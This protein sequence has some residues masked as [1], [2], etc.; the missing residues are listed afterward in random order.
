MSTINDDN[1]ND[2]NDNDDNDNETKV[3]IVTETSDSED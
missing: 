3:G 1:D 2:D